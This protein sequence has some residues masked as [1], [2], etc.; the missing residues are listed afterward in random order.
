MLIS[1]TAQAK[2]VRLT[3]R[4][5]IVQGGTSASKTFSIIPILIDKAIIHS[6]YEISIVAESIPHLKR[7]ALKDFIKIMRWTGM[8]DEKALNKSDLKYTFPNGSYIEFFSAD[9]SDK[10][11]GARRD[12]L[13][14]NECNNVSF[15]AYQQLA[16]RT[17][18]YIYLD[19]NPTSEFWVHENLLNDEDAELLILTYKDNEALSDT[20]V[21]EIEKAKEKAK[22]SKYWENWWRVYGLGQTGVLEGVV[23]TNWKTIDKIPEE[24]RLIGSGLDFGYTNDPTAN[25][26][27]Y[28]FNDTII[29]D[30]RIYENGMTNKDIAKRFDLLGVE[31]NEYITADS[32]EPK[33]IDELKGYGYYVKPVLKGRDS[34]NYGISLLQENE[35]YVTSSSVNLIKEL[36]RYSWDEDRSG[37]KLNKPIDDYNHAIDAM[38]YLAVMK[39]GKTTKKTRKA[40]SHAVR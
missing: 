28:K 34:V 30:E 32:A 11:R 40:K 7:G 25:V 24:A 14:I 20:I 35:F 27:A 23:F 29:W 39:I 6:N 31:K 10:L 8:Y 12:I 21:K 16:I 13:F 1:T 22:T 33:S 19:F 5:R 26:A 2:I 36:R 9:H 3:K 15:E 38:R 17:K 18:K 4:V 37:N